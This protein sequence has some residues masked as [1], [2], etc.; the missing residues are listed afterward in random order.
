MN[1]DFREYWTVEELAD[2][3]DKPPK[4]VRL[5]VR[6]GLLR[7]SV[8]TPGGLLI[9]PSEAWH[10]IEMVGDMEEEGAGTESNGDAGE[11][12]MRGRKV[13]SAMVPRRHVTGEPLPRGKV[14]P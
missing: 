8:R 5:A 9:K 13:R 12:S 4:F 3:I 10:C 2:A 1:M 7:G 6:E 11:A 14:E